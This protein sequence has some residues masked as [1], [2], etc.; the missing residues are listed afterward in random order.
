MHV[1]GEKPAFVIKR[2]PTFPCIKFP[3]I[4]LRACCSMCKFTWARKSR[5]KL[6]SC[7]VRCFGRVQDWA[8]NHQHAL[9]SILFWSL[10]LCLWVWI[11]SWCKASFAAGDQQMSTCPSIEEQSRRNRCTAISEFYKVGSLIQDWHTKLWVHTTSRR[12]VWNVTGLCI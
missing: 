10:S 11:W 1:L 12:M 3:P 9:M 5:M 2:I 8:E 6:A 7:P 4:K